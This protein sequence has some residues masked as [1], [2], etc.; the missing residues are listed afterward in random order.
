MFNRVELKKETKEKIGNGRWLKIFGVEFLA[1]LLT[2]G[3]TVVLSLLMGLGVASGS[4]ALVVIFTLVFLVAV[5]LLFP[6]IIY[7]VYRYYQNVW[8]GQDNGFQ[9]V[10]SGFKDMGVSIRA[11]F[12]QAL[13]LGLWSMLFGAVMGFLFGITGYGY[14]SLMTNDFYYG[15]MMSTSAAYS[16]ALLVVLWIVYI[17]WII[18]LINRTLAYSQMYF[19]LTEHPELGAKRGLNISKQ[20]MK[21]HKGEFFTL[22]LSFIP[23]VLL[24]M[25]PLYVGTIIGAIITASTHAAGWVIALMILGCIGSLLIAMYV[26]PYMNITMAGYYDWVKKINLEQ[27]VLTLQDFNETQDSFVKQEE[28]IVEGPDFIPPDLQ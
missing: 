1:G 17:A 15:Q 7:G 12:W 9:D 13:W 4:T 21:G 6:P 16:G 23:W 18:I 11:Y 27:N 28:I 25:A 20:M 19:S 10:L 3:I 5:I 2:L 24:M 8:R 22:S 14:S 26:G